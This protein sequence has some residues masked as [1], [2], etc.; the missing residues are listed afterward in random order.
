MWAQ[1]PDGALGNSAAGSL[2][3][4]QPGASVLCLWPKKQNQK[5]HD[6]RFQF[7]QTR[8]HRLQMASGMPACPGHGPGPAALAPLPPPPSMGGARDSGG[9]NAMLP[10]AWLWGSLG[11]L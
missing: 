7:L 6:A 10:G 2:S 5:R 4:E 3:K 11:L 1:D 9:K 8:R